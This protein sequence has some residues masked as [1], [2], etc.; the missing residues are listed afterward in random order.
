M[1][2]D[3]DVLTWNYY[4]TNAAKTF[5]QLWNTQEFSDVT[6]VTVDDM[7]IKAHKMIISYCSPFFKN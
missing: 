6:L 1:D 7:Q 3:K 5:S 2:N 4:E